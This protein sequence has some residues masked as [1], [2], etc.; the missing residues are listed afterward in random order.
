MTV[1][2]MGLVILRVHRPF[3]LELTNTI[4]CESKNR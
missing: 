2:E 3:F 4:I 1:K